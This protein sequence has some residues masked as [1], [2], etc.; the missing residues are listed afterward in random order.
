MEA[1]QPALALKGKLA[2]V[3][4]AS[5]GLGASM[6]FDL[7]SR[8]A[9]VCLTYVSE[10]STPAV[11][12]LAAKISA[13]SHKPHTYI[14]RG[15]LSTIDGPQQIITQLLEATGTPG[16][17]AIHIL[18]NNAGCEK[19]VSLDKLTVDDYTQVFDLNVRGTILMTQAVLPYLQPKGRIINISSV[20][21]R[22]AFA[23]LSLYC[24]SKAAIEGLTRSWAME[25]GH[26]GTTVNSVNPGPVQ[27][28][29]LENIP[30]EIIEM[31]KGLTAVERR[32]G[33]PKEVADIVSWLAGVESAWVSG[34]C[35]SASGG[36]AMY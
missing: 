21:S 6:A 16:A 31:Q 22:A 34:Q 27:T 7:A 32:L 25:L 15:D 23:N 14:C 11:Q 36:Y 26:N 24:A 28:E 33:M 2:I 12:E 18:V 8:G 9:D 35:I 19:V 30:K 3:T 1:S 10:K 13:L 5:R 29:L 4:G 20:G 17:L